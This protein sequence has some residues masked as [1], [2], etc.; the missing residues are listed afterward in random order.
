MGSGGCP[1]LTG[2]PREESTLWVH[3]YTQFYWVYPYT[4]FGFWGL[5]NLG[6]GG[7]RSRS[8][9][10]GRPGSGWRYAGIVDWGPPLLLRGGQRSRR[11]GGRGA[12]R[13]GIVGT[14]RG[15]T[16]A[17]VVDGGGQRLCL[18]AFLQNTTSFF[19]KLS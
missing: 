17:A 14:R 6:S 13:G 5:Y 7:S 12:L 8:G 18:T 2:L 16:V 4:L 10:G 11:P 9:L 19:S 15:D 1:Y 3:P